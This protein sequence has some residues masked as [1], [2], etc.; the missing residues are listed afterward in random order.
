LGK[1]DQRFALPSLKFVRHG[2]GCT[3]S[4]TQRL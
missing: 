4:A 2:F 3:G 1:L